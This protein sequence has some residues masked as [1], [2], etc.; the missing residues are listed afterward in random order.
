MCF[1]CFDRNMNW[2]QYGLL[3][4]LFS[5]C[6]RRWLLKSRFHCIITTFSISDT[7]RSWYSIGCLCQLLV[8]ED[9]SFFFLGVKRIRFLYDWFISL[10]FLFKDFPLMA[11]FPLYTQNVHGYCIFGWRS[12]FSNGN[13]FIL[14][15]S[16]VDRGVSLSLGRG[17][18][19]ND[20]IN[21][22]KV[23]RSS[24]FFFILYTMTTCNFCKPR[25]MT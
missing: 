13:V 9:G 21:K 5:T 8:V 12:L 6:F 15:N 17:I 24:Y 25:Q 1:F 14:G 19:L 16:E 18:T 20:M 22:S 2:N 7:S 23:T 10:F 4:F 11:K 3:P